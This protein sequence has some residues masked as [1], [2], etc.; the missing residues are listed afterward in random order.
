VRR[1]ILLKLIDS[2]PEVGHPQK[3]PDGAFS[4][5]SLLLVHKRL[6]TFEINVA[7]LLMFFGTPFAL[8]LRMG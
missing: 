5:V 8:P 1:K 2:C 3:R 6:K 4:L 7:Q